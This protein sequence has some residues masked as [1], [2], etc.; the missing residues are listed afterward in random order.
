MV[1]IKEE[2]VVHLKRFIAESFEVELDNVD[3]ESD[4]YEFGIDSISILQLKHRCC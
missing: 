3:E 2:I 1:S 4:F